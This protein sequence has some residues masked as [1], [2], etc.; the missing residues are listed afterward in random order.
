MN[1]TKETKQERDARKEA[2]RTTRRIGW[3]IFL[4]VMGVLVVFGGVWLSTK[5]ETGD[6][7]T[8]VVE[9]IS[10]TDHVRGETTNP[11]AILIEYSDFECPACADYEPYLQDILDEYGS[12]GLA[13]VYRHYPLPQHSKALIM[14]KASEA[15]GAQG[16]FWE[17]HDLIFESQETWTK[18]TATEADTMIESLAKK[19]NLDLVKFKTDL[20]SQTAEDKIKA[21]IASAQKARVLGTPTFFLN[22]KEIN[23]G[24]SDN[25]ARLIGEALTATTT[26]NVTSELAK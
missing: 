20:N 23:P 18:V 6:S 15:A 8:G 16:K 25:F 5:N 19:L 11:K 24:T 13:L 2:A 17:M 21:D 4:A 10:A 9:A 3:V 14:A 22:G 7:N 1:E 12:K 26:N